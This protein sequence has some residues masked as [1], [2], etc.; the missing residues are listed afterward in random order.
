VLAL[1]TSAQAIL[2]GVG[3]GTA[4]ANGVTYRLVASIDPNYDPGGTLYTIAGLSEQGDFVWGV[5]ELPSAQSGTAR[6]GLS[7][8]TAA[9]GE[10][11]ISSNATGAYWVTT[12]GL[13][14][15][16]QNADVTSACD[17][18]TFS[19]GVYSS[20]RLGNYTGTLHLASTTSGIGTTGTSGPTVN[21]TN[22]TMGGVTLVK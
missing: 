5:S 11:G 18:T 21:L 9:D 15:V 2:Y 22:V 20:C 6:L 1:R 14:Q 17:Q 19:V 12:S 10:G 7:T 3:V 13:M 16:T 4:S 8:D